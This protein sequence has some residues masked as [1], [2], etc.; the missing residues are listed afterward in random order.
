MVQNG[1]TY[2]EWDRLE[3]NDLRKEREE[4]DEEDDTETP[5]IRLLKKEVPEELIVEYVENG[6]KS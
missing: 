6:A 5:S 1:I 4:Y 3:I 2:T